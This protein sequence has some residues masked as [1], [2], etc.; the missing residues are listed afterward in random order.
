[1]EARAG[2]V[3]NS[4]SLIQECTR[5]RGNDHAGVGHPCRLGLHTSVKK[6]RCAAARGEV[7]SVARS[8]RR[9]RWPG[10]VHMSSGAVGYGG[11]RDRSP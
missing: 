10:P 6:G 2:T 4:S 11:P 8:P 9:P 3:W 5:E 1:M 7:N